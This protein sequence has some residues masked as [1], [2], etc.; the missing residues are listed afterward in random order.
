VTDKKLLAYRKNDG[1]GDW[2]MAM[3][4]LKM[5]N[6]QYPNID[7]HVYAENTNVDEETAEF[8]E[9]LED[10][11]VVI[12]VATVGKGDNH[13]QKRFINGVYDIIDNMD[14]NLTRVLHAEPSEYDYY[15][16]HMIYFEFQAEWN[17]L[18]P[19]VP[20]DYI[21]NHLIHGM[22]KKFNEETKLNLKYDKNV[23]ARYKNIVPFG[24]QKP[25]VVIPSCGRDDRKKGQQ[26]T[27]AWGTDNYK[28][29]AARLRK[30]YYIVQVGSN[31][32]P[33]IKDVDQVIVDQP[34]SEVLGVMKEAEFYVGEI[35]GLVHLAG[36]HAI[37]TYAIYCGGKEHPD[38]TGY[39]NQIPIMENNAS[40]DMVYS[41]I[42]E[43]EAHD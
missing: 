22:V 37:K 7:I 15:S 23:L 6:L 36:H 17:S 8:H 25:Y 32:Q 33:V 20:K 30:H 43:E 29:L 26:D 4:V 16:K 5:V 10:G 34:F 24:G 19:E 41:K 40:V 35:N 31:D 12:T 9:I 13:R 14:V 2:I 39:K 27:K 28:E 3:S 42:I 21:R 11:K 38:F 18:Y 1:L